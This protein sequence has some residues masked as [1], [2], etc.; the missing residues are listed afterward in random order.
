[1]AYSVVFTDDHVSRR[2]T[3]TKGCEYVVGK[4]NTVLN[5]VYMGCLNL[6]AE[7]LWFGGNTLQVLIS[8][9]YH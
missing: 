3:R 6:E 5:V 7:V 4:E 1:M 2:D 9:Y 8:N